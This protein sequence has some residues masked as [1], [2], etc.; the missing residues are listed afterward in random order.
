MHTNQKLKDHCRSNSDC[1][2]RIVGITRRGVA[3]LKYAPSVSNRYM[4][5][6]VAT[7]Y[8]AYFVSLFVE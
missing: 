6:E 4:R 5:K 2:R 3:T 1:D 7:L 8:I